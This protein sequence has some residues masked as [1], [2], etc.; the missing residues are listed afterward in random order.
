M[1]KRYKNI[2]DL[3]SDIFAASPGLA[4]SESLF[5][6]V[7]DTVFCIKNRRRQYV[8]VN[9]AFV[10]RA[11]VSNKLAILG[12]TAREIFPPL[13]AAGYEQQDDLVFTTGQEV[14]DKLEM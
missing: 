14:R 2:P 13:L 10:S 6:G 12:H 9:S 11:R 3:R 1:P 8:S 7:Y 4:V 5:E